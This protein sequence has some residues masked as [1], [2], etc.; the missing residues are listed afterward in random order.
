MNKALY[1][2][3]FVQLWE[4]MVKEVYLKEAEASSEMAEHAWKHTTMP[5]LEYVIFIGDPSN[6]TNQISRGQKAREKRWQK[7]RA[8]RP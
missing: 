5:P 3:E 8:K 6:L 4:E 7:W 2:K 1:F